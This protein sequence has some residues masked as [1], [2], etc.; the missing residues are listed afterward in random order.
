MNEQEL[1]KNY[2]RAFDHLV[3]LIHDVDD[4]LDRSKRAS[5]DL[6]V[7]QYEHL[8]K[9]YVQQLADLIGK[10]PKAVTVQAV[11]H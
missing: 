5:D 1:I 11:T 7:R 10:A 9:D 4:A 6:G 2:V 3:T 8:K